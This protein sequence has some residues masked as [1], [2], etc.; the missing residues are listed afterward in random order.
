M[1][2]LYDWPRAVALLQAE[3]PW[4]A[5]GSAH[6]YH[7][8]TFGYLLGE[9]VRRTSGSTLGTWLRTHIAGPRGLDLHIGLGAADQ[10]RCADLVPS[11]ADARI[12]ERSRPMMQA[13][14]TPDSATA[15]AFMNPLAPRGYMNTAAFRGAELPAM[16]GHASA[17][18][19]AQLYG[20]LAV[21]D[22]G[23]CPPALLAEATRPQS[24]GDDAVLRQPTCFGLGF[25]LSRPAL[26][27]GLSSASFGHAGAGGSLAF[28]DP[29]A[30]IGFCFLMNRMRPGAVTGNDS[31]MAL[32]ATLG[33]LLG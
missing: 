24:E 13:M 11:G 6:G 3:R 9:P 26:E 32:V 14:Q 22:P 15:A 12:P 7:A 18:A 1:D 19:L 25:M 16:N 17:R 20:A 27:V 10:A 30:R 31:A 4:W 5:P 33:E 23:L 21:G 28:A 29:D 8:R 2:D